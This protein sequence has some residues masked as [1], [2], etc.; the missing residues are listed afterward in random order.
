MKQKSIL[1]A[2]IL[3]GFATNALGE[4]P[5]TLSVKRLS[6]ETALKVAQG[7]ITACR[8]KGIQIGVTVVD[9]SGSP[10]VV[11]RDVLA[12]N[13]TLEV[14]AKKAYTAVSFNAATSAL[15]GRFQSPHSVAKID[16]LVMSAGGLPIEAG[17]VLYGA[18][19]VSGAP[20]GEIDEACAQAGVEAVLADLEMAGL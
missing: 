19:G 12:P 4:S 5:M 8:E 20:G 15:E 10:Q 14:S 13:L 16:S 7:A 1:A 11:L 9:R 2:F 18:V 3:C 17:G 6:L